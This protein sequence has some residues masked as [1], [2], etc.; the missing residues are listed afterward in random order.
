MY[1]CNWISGVMDDLLMDFRYRAVLK[2]ALDKTSTHIS[3]FQ[4]FSG[5]WPCSL[6]FSCFSMLSSLSPSESCSETSS[7]AYTCSLRVYTFTYNVHVRGVVIHSSSQ[8]L[9][10]HVYAVTDYVNKSK[11]CFKGSLKFC[12]TTKFSLGRCSY[13]V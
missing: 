9:W 2:K 11:L 3:T 12:I 7:M 5:V 13:T 1:T 4:L 8:S 6:P 10:V